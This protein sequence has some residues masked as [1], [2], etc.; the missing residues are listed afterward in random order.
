[1]SIEAPFF[2]AFFSWDNIKTILDDWF[3][4]FLRGGNLL[5]P[6]LIVEY[7]G[8]TPP[9][10]WVECDGATYETT[11]YPDL[12]KVIGVESSPGMFDVPDAT[13]TPPTVGQIWI[14]KV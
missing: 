10:G 12:F 7:A 5:T 14:I 3:Q 11:K 2:P 8:S 6:G 13:A 9:E 4:R 1:M